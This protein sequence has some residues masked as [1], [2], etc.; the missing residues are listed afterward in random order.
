MFVVVAAAE[1]SR[2]DTL[3]ADARVTPS[4]GHLNHS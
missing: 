1:V 4:S 3:T 2:L